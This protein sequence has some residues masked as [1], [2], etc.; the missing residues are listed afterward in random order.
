MFAALKIMKFYIVFI[1]Q[2]IRSLTF[3]R[4]W[5]LCKLC[6]SYFLSL[7]FK[8]HMFCALPSCYSIEPTNIC[9]L[10][11]PECPTGNKSSIVPKGKMEKILCEKLIPQIKDSALFV[12]LYFQGE[13]FVNDQTIS[14]IKLVSEA[15]IMSSISTNAHFITE[16]NAD[17][18]VNSGLTKLIVSLDGYDQKSY[19][20]YRRN[21]S[22]QKVIDGMK[23]IQDAKK[24]NNS[25]L[26]LVELQCLLFKHT[27]K[28]KEEIR[29]IGELYGADN[30]Q[31]KTAQF[32]DSQNIDMIPSKKKN[33][34]YKVE[35]GELNIKKTLKNQCWKMWCSCIVAWNG[36]VLPC[37]F[38]KNHT[39]AFGN[40][41]T[42]SMSEIWFSEKYKNFRKLIHTNRKQV[43]MC[44][45]CSQ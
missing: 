10:Q 44:Q 29:K 22:F 33:S 17:A 37:C 32:Y 4:L 27:E 2:I 42:Q 3:K 8:K 9:N 36:N 14:F 45:N 12:N 41:S 19:E 1:G 28:H 24:R 26:P 39:F 5:N 13:P 18:I 11:C 35:D 25:N 6:C 30:I 21:G 38:D 7:R 31:F 40:V 15:K 20:K 43:S 34:R 16:N 23:A